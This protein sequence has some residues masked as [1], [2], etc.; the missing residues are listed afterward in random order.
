M[1]PSIVQTNRNQWG[2]LLGAHNEDTEQ[3]LKD[4]ASTYVVRIQIDKMGVHFAVLE[5]PHK[6]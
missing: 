5:I 3:L 1:S 6:V 2:T 4:G